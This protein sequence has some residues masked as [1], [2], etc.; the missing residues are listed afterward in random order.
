VPGACRRA[1]RLVFC[2]EVCVVDIFLYGDEV[3]RVHSYIDN[4]WITSDLGDVV[5]DL[6]SN[7][8]FATVYDVPEPAT[9]VLLG[10][11]AVLM[12]KK[13]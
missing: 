13:K 11:G 2:F 6:M 12:R 1:H 4:G 8:D 7:P 5:T 9:I 3:S 10:L